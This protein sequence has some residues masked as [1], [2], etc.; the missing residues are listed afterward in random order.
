MKYSH[1]LKSETPLHDAISIGSIEALDFLITVY[2]ASPSFSSTWPL[3]RLNKI[4]A[5]DKHSLSKS[6]P[7]HLAVEKGRLDMVELLLKN[8][9]DVNMNQSW[10]QSALYLAFQDKNVKMMR[11]LLENGANVHSLKHTVQNL[12]RD[13]L[14]N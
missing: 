6:R 8:G 14:F 1:Y 2:S 10:G 7:L 12:K 9:A 13:T 11:L 5:A 3:T 4:N